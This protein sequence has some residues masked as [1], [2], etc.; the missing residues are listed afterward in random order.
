LGDDYRAGGCPALYFRQILVSK[1][2]NPTQLQA[3]LSAVGSVVARP[4]DN[5]HLRGLVIDSAEGVTA[6][7]GFSAERRPNPSAETRLEAKLLEVAQAN[8]DISERYLVR[9]AQP[10]AAARTASR[11][12][13]RG[14]RSRKR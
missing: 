5:S 6:F 3:T 12:S 10:V 11:Y 1:T 14:R 7:S 9:A 2:R 4:A 8:P 13:V